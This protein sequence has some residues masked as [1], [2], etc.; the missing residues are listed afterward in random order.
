MATT[1]C[2]SAPVARIGARRSLRAPSVNKIFGARVAPAR[3]A[4]AMKIYAFQ[5]TLKTPDG[6]QQIECAGMWLTS[7]VRL[8][9]RQVG[10]AGLVCKTVVRPYI[11]LV[12]LELPSLAIWPYPGLHNMCGRLLKT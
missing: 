2:A 11:D 7:A 12:G 5:I 9:Y 1:V 10:A 8:F 3:A 4:A 6:E